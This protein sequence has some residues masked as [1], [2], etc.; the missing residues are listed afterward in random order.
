MRNRILNITNILLILAC[1]G[2]LYYLSTAEYR[3]PSEIARSQRLLSGAGRGAADTETIYRPGP[4]PPVNMTR[5][6]S[7]LNRR[8]MVPIVTPTPTPTPTPPPPP[9]PP[10]LFE[11]VY[12]WNIVSIIDENTVEF[13]DDRTKENFT[14]TIGGPTREGED[15]KKDKVDVR[16]V[17]VDM[18]ELKV[19]LGFRDQT[20]EKTW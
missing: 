3:P 9:P 1:G 6:Y 13:F 4:A 17:A 18:V 12:A 2:C 5:N 20:V 19:T 10:N 11:A 16:L 14:L 8:I 15:K 7:M